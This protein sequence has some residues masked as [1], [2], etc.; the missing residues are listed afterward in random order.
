MFKRSEL[1]K[2]AQYA[3]ADSFAMPHD[4]KIAILRLLIEQEDIALF[5]EKQ[6]AEKAHET[7]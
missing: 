3:V 1:Y 4:E 2:K 6:E 5:C 7:V